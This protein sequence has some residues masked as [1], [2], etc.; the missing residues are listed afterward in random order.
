MIITP[1]SVLF[2]TNFGTFWYSSAGG[3]R[4]IENYLVRSRGVF[5]N[6]SGVEK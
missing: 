6:T 4:E 5:V 1:V 2:L 3:R